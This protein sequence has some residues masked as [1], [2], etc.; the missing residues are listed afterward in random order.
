[1]NWGYVALVAAGA[2]ALWLKKRNSD[3]QYELTAHQI[4][5]DKNGYCTMVYTDGHGKQ[6]AVWSDTKNNKWYRV[7]SCADVDEKTA[8]ALTEIRNKAIQKALPKPKVLRI[9]PPKD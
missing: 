4:S 6:N 9:G 8:E 5:V 3:K 7:D 2:A 1:M